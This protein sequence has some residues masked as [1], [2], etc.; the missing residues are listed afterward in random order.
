MADYISIITDNFISLTFGIFLF[1]TFFLII[2]F[3]ATYFISIRVKKE[4]DNILHFLTLLAHKK[5]SFILDSNYTYEFYKISKLLNKVA[6]KLSK[7]EKQKAKQNAKLKL[8]NKQK[9]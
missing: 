6:I 1:I 7:R 2:A 3:L 4:T 5:P 8:A 9:Q